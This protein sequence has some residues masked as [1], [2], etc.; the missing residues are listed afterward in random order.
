MSQTLADD[1]EVVFDQPEESAGG[2]EPEGPIPNR[3]KEEAWLEATEPCRGARPRR[4]EF[5]RPVNGG[6][7]ATLGGVEDEDKLRNGVVPVLRP[8]QQIQQEEEVQTPPRREPRRNEGHQPRGPRVM[9][10]ESVLGPGDLAGQ[11]KEIAD[12]HRPN[13]EWS[14]VAALEDTV[15]R[16]QRDLE[17][18]QTEN[19]FLRTPRAPWPVPLVRQAAPTTTKV[20]WF[21]GSTSWEQYQQVFDAIVLSNGWGDVTA[22]LQLLSHLQDDALSVALLILMPLQASRKELTDALSSHYG[23]PGRLANYRRE[24]DKT[25]RKRGEDPS[26][27]AITLETLAV[28]AF[29]NMGQTA[30]L[31]LIRDRFIAGHE[32]CD[33][34]RYLDCV[35]PDTPLRDIVDRCRVWESHGNTEVRRVSKPMPEPVYPT[36]VVEQPDYETE[37]VCVVT[38]NKP[39]SQVDQS[40]ELLKKL[41]EVLT[42]TAGGGGTDTTAKGTRAPD[43]TPLEKLVQLLLS[44]TAKREPAP[45]TP[46]EPTG[47]EALR[48]TYFTGQQSPRQGPRFRQVR[49]NWSD[50][51]CF[52]CGKTG[53][54]ATRCP[55]LDVTFPFILPGWKAEKTPTGYL[56]ISPKMTTDRRRAENED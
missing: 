29:G 20:P 11:R 41:L 49:R 40:E 55:T 9:T 15:S 45:P 23:T 33:L 10:D 7:G 24:F 22:A 25:V 16:M 39:N 52:S 44:E 31:R 19:R 12:R 32:S 48:Q 26:K 42:P 30:R 35:P 27:F 6:L 46:A 21:N 36:Y 53:H 28:K 3:H 4:M 43:V 34:R 5:D 47:L 51:K 2:M 37:P 50:V 13:N 17:E 38:V 54:S 1:S 18:L 56:M 14:P 8:E